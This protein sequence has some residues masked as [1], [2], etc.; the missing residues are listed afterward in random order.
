MAAIPMSGNA[1][2]DDHKIALL[3]E[4]VRLYGLTLEE[5]YF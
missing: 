2:A 3:N 5:G 1:T 4:L